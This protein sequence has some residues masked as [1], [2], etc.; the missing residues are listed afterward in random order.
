MRFPNQISIIIGVDEVGRGPIAGPVTVCA[1]LC[2]RQDLTKLK[3]RFPSVN[4]SK[5]VSRKCREDL[6]SKMRSDDLVRFKIASVS[7]K[8]IDSHG[9]SAAIK[10]ALAKTLKRLDADPD[11]TYVLLDGRL[12]APAKFKNQ[13]TIIRGDSKEWL[14]GAASIVAKVFRDSIMLRFSKDYPGY[15]LERHKGYGTKLH[16]EKIREQGICPIHRAS[17]LSEGLDR[18][19]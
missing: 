12:Y 5:K 7:A 3:K 18:Y 13:T 15:G 1:A 6:S 14:I 2:R 11:K 4:D 19:M 8:F 10:K 16:Y 17:F 9:I